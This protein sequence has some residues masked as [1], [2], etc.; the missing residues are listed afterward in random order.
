MFRNMSSAEFAKY[1]IDHI[2]LAS[3]PNA[4]K[5]AENFNSATDYHFDE[6]LRDVQN[7]LHTLITE[8]KLDLDKC[9]TLIALCSNSLKKYSEDKITKSYVIDDFIIELWKVYNGH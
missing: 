4:L 6:F 8:N 3:L 2:G 9:Y 5:I 1:M 7:Y